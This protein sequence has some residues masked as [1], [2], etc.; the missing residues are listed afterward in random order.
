MTVWPPTTFGELPRVCAVRVPGSEPFLWNVLGPRLEAD[1]TPLPPGTDVWDPTRPVGDR[2]CV[3]PEPRPLWGM[4]AAALTSEEFGR[5]RLDHRVITG[6]GIVWAVTGRPGFR[7][8]G[9]L[10]VGL[11]SPEHGFGGDDQR[12]MRPADEATARAVGRLG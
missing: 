6:S 11:F 2:E 7:A 3:V 8:N 9:V 1:D 5:L 12:G 10:E 4:G